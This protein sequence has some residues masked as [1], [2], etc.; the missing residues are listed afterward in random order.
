MKWREEIYI[1]IY[2]YIYIGCVVS[3]ICSK[4]QEACIHWKQSTGPAKRNEQ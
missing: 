4:Q 1:Y 2:I 3:R